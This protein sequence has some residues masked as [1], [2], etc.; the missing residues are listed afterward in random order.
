MLNFMALMHCVVYMGYVTYL[1]NCFLTLHTLFLVKVQLKNNIRAN[2]VTENDY[3]N[4]QNVIF[5]IVKTF[6]TVFDQDRPLDEMN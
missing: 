2:I 1:H 3:T 5:I 4:A 6:Q